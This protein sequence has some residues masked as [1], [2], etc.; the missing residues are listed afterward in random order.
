MVHTPGIHSVNIQTLNPQLHTPACN[1]CGVDVTPAGSTS[2]LLHWLLPEEVR[3]G[4][5]ATPFSWLEL[6]SGVTRA[7]KRCGLACTG[8]DDIGVAE[9]MSATNPIQLRKSQYIAA[10]YIACSTNLVP[11]T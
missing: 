11:E 7:R 6:A 10:I 5:D 1:R 8:D 9:G 3:E 4:P 2:A